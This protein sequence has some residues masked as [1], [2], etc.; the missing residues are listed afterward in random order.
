M[1]T[2][3]EINISL[4]DKEAKA[5]Y[6]IFAHINAQIPE[7]YFHA[8]K[9]EHCL[10]I[11]QLLIEKEY[12]KSIVSIL[13]KLLPQKKEDKV[14]TKKLTQQTLSFNKKNKKAKNKNNKKGGKHVNFN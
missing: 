11:V 13:D 14:K 3:K 10:L 1:K 4:T 6:S 7:C 9:K 12:F 8:K 5:L 2:K